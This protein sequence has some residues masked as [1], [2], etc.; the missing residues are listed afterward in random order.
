MNLKPA[1]RLAYA[2]CFAL[3][4]NVNAADFIK[5]TP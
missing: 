1:H 4:G 2:A 3:M 5:P